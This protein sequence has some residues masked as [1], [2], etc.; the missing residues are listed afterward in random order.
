MKTLCIVILIVSN[1]LTIFCA[2]AAVMNYLSW[3]REHKQNIE[4]L[5][6]WNEFIIDNFENPITK[7]TIAKRNTLLKNILENK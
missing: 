7:K 1:F 5:I 4:H 3:K 2:I 6:E